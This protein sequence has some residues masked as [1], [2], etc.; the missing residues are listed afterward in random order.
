MLAGATGIDL[1]LLV[2]AA[3]EGVKPQTREHLAIVDLLAIERGIV[4][5]TQG[6]SGPSRACR[7]D[8]HRSPRA[9]RGH[10][11]SRRARSSRFLRRRERVFPTC[12]RRSTGSA[13]DA[14]RSDR[15]SLTAGARLPIDRVF[16][17]EG[18]GTVVT[19]T[20]WS[21]AIRPGDALQILPDDRSVRVRR[22]EVHDAEVATAVAG[23][24]T[25]VALHGVDREEIARGDWLVAPER[26]RASDLLDVRI[27]SCRKPIVRS[28]RG[29]ACACTWER[30]RSS[31][32]WCCSRRRRS[33]PVGTRLP[34]FGSSARSWPRPATASWSAPI[35]RR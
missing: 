19:G 26:F 12:S 22:V 17:I 28:A 21:G 1:V 20:L 34:N 15:R 4:A 9:A 27:A 13:A 31:A 5:L 29:P 14:A 25:A 7:G 2:V 8:P 10:P 3:D 24:R 35:V 16:S 6:R 23:Q 32:A 33:S 18:I 30:A 11:P